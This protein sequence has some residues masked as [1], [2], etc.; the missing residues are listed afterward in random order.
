[1]CELGC[2]HYVENS[3]ARVLPE[4]VQQSMKAPE[5]WPGVCRGL[6]GNGVCIPMLEQDLFH[7][8]GRPLLNGL[9]GVPK[10]EEEQ[11]VPIHRLIMDLRHSTTMQQSGERDRG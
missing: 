4:E 7:V 6:L 2:K 9:F 11:D 3:G 1:M 8:D 5:A 10:G